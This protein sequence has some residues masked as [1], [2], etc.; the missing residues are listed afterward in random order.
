MHEGKRRSTWWRRAWR[1]RHRTRNGVTICLET[2]DAFCRGEEVAGVLRQVD[3]PYVKAVWDVHHRYRMGEA[4]EDA[5]DFIGARLAH[6]H[7]KDAQRR[8]D[9]S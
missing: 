5:W 9:G 1:R 6:V 2:H 4:V 3:S 8:E 7:M